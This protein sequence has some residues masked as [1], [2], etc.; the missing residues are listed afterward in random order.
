MMGIVVSM[1][2]EMGQ[3]HLKKEELRGTLYTKWGPSENIYW[4]VC[5]LYALYSLS[6]ID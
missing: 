1:N 6:S 4:L 5:I 3:K 2:R